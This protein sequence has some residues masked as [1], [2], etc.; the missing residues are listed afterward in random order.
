MRL[1]KYLVSGFTL[2]IA[3]M[4]VP[5]MAQSYEQHNLVTDGTD[6]D[7][8]N[9]W[10][11]VSSATSPWWVADNG[12][13]KSTLYMGEGQKVLLGNGTIPAVNVPGAPTGIVFNGDA[14]A[15]QLTTGGKSGRAVFIFASEDGT[16]SGWNNSGDASQAVVAYTSPT[17]AIYK[18]L[19]IA[20]TTA[21][22]RLYA[23]NFKGAVVEV[24]DGAFALQPSGG[25]ADPTIPAGFA[26][27][28]IQTI[29][30]VVYVTYAK[31]DEDAE[32]EVAGKGLGYVN[33][34]DTAGNLIARIASRGQLNAP[35]GIAWAP[36]EFGAKGHLLIGN[37]G[38]GRILQ[39]DPDKHRH[40]G[41]AQFK[42]FL[43]L[44]NGEPVQIEG[45]WAL[46]FGH[47]NANSGDAD[48]LYFTAG[49]N[50]E[51]GGLFGYLEPADHSGEDEG[52]ES[53]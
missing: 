10:G 12:T 44:T 28:G 38:N 4:A 13:A 41:E 45:L 20:A 39:F 23:T 3:L 37:F 42:G 43:E 7:L 14:A 30:D 6:P 8:I 46:Q 32:D 50:D 9:P 16:I 19:A 18:G 24:F 1:R 17:G 25:F 33:A 48:E 11:L 27:F 36:D 40:H 15:F 47:G 31:Q 52:D 21:G 29:G 35:W 51:E 53:N 34:F 22:P 26:P 2:A 5:A 49:P